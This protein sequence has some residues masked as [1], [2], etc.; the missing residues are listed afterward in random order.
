MGGQ[1]HQ[2]SLLLPTSYPALH[3]QVTHTCP[4]PLEVNLS[5]G[6]GTKPGRRL[7]GLPCR[8]LLLLIVRPPSSCSFGLK[9]SS[10]GG[11]VVERP[12]CQQ[13]ELGITWH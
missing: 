11:L 5:A 1:Y 2:P 4:D 7:R 10:S 13:L 3:I 12:R 8:L 6:P 9:V